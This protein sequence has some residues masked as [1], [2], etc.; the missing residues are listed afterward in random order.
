VTARVVVTTAP[1][2]LEGL[3]A[4][5]EGVNARLVRHPLLDVA[6]PVSWAAFD[7]ALA[8]P[9]DAIVLTSPRAAEVLAERGAHV[10]R[11]PSV[12]AAGAAS[13]APLRAHG[14]S[15][16]SADGGTAS[17]SAAMSLAIA[18][19]GAGAHGRVLHV[20]GEPHR[21]ELAERLR[22]GGCTVETV[23][24]YRS[25]PVSDVELSAVLLRAHVLV[26][27]SPLLVRA[28]AAQGDAA[29]GPA[30]VALG[31]TTADAI[32][33]AGLPLA[34]VAD[35]PSAPGV[36]LAIQRALHLTSRE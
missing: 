5:L 10:S 22:D 6:P 32:R 25:V 21:T 4:A 9:W 26:V 33:A 29:L 20:A 28:L 31:A 12:W 18:M 2:S 3:E 8:A 35:D 13:A 11:H 14:W 19:L 15:V 24:A 30:W 23:I 7:A 16:Q 34:A 17:Q 27:G 36:A 1:R